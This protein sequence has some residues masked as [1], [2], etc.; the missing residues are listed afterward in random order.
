[1]LTTGCVESGAMC[2]LAH[3]RQHLKEPVAGLARL[4]GAAVPPAG[5]TPEAGDRSLL[6]RESSMNQGHSEGLLGLSS[7]W[8]PGSPPREGLHSSCHRGRD[9]GSQR[10]C[11]RCTVGPPLN[12]AGPAYMLPGTFVTRLL[13]PVR[14][15]GLL[16]LPCQPRGPL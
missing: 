10:T 12:P 5:V 16:C 2:S 9:R 15:L 4:C 1:M 13:L 6:S 14:G 7:Q 3:S 8:T 11:L